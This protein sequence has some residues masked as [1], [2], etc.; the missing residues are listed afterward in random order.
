MAAGKK[1]Q[2]HKAVGTEPYGVKGLTNRN[3]NSNKEV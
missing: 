3:S 1:T 2:E